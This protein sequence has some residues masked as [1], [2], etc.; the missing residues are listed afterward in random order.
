MKTRVW[1]WLLKNAKESYIYIVL[2]TVASVVLSVISLRF[3]LESKRIIDIATG[4]AQGRFIDVCISIVLLLLLMLIV[5]I[6][7][8]F[9]NVHANSRFEIA[10]KSHIFKTLLKKDYLSVAAYHS[11]EL[12][13][14]I[15]SD[16]GVIVGGIVTIIPKAALFLTSIIGA[17]ILLC[18][19]D[20]TLAL[21]ILA[22]GPMVF[23]GARLYYIIFSNRSW[24]F[25]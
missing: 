5:Q 19:M 1:K 18:R 7:I 12:L 2:L 14:R 8:N 16:V 11:G 3:S 4:A 9:I 10:L 17:F 15:N 13:N 22:V 23:I 6:I 24:S 25:T 21:I 20:M